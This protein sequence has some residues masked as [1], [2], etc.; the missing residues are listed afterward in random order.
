MQRI[1]LSALL[2]TTTLNATPL[3]FGQTYQLNTASPHPITINLE[4]PSYI[5]GHL[6]SSATISEATIVDSAGAPV[7]DLIA[8]PTKEAEIF[9]FAEHAGN[10]QINLSTSSQTSK[11]VTIDIN[12]IP[13]KK[14]QYFSPSAEQT[15]PLIQTT[16]T[17]LR[18]NKKQV[19]NTFWQQIENLGG[20][21][22]VEYT[23]HDTAL[24][25]FLHKGFADNVRVLGSPYGGHA[26][27]TQLA[28]S[29]IWFKTF[30]VP[31]DTRLSYRIA[32]NVPQLIDDKSREQRRAVLATASSDPLNPRAKFSQADNLFGAAST[33]SL[34]DAPPS[35]L[36]KPQQNVLRGSVV[37]H[38]YQQPQSALPR[39]VSIYQPN[40]QYAL[41]M[42]APLVI[43]FDGD[44]YLNKVSTPAILDNLI[45]QGQIPPLRALFINPPLPSMRAKELTPNSTYANFLA[46]E[47]MPWLCDSHDIC[48]RPEHTVL[49][50][51]SFGGL[52]AMSIALN[53][54]ER[55]GNVLSQSGSF[56]WQPKGS[57]VTH[58]NWM[59][60]QVT[61]AAKKDVTIYMNAG[62]FEVEPKPNSILITNRQLY[63]TLRELNYKVTYQEVAGGHDYFNWQFMLADGLTTLFNNH[64]L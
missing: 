55:F 61:G 14:N 38:T 21:P 59:A 56:W 26:Y 60:N 31:T 48:P 36:D 64:N 42:Q 63:S 33:I 5:R 19:E 18:N 7:K 1:A 37:Q 12:R 40:P 44:A 22:L 58:Q 39:S 27:L 23:N 30:E 2:A 3:E 62:V 45:A 20:T 13:L 6:K 24:V 28:Q 15:S 29:N 50:G 53:H 51:S 54:P 49:S 41:D 9:W 17:K 43:F 11:K 8:V 10:Y 25:T 16:L 35:I 47:F 52:A 57:A 46:N 34:R 4:S 32:V